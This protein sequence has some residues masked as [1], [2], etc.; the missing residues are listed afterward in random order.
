LTLEAPRQ[1]AYDT[2]LAEHR[3][4]PSAIALSVK[5]GEKKQNTLWVAVS[6]TGLVI[7]ENFLS[8]IVIRSDWTHTSN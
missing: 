4:E 1:A 5:Q 2:T 6:T 3:A 8:N 7:T